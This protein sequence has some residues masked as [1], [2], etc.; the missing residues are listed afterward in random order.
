[1][2]G[3]GLWTI[4][5]VTGAWPAAADTPFYDRCVALD[6]S[7]RLQVEACTFALETEKLAADQ[8]AH[9][10]TRRATGYRGTGY[11]RYADA[12][13]EQAVRLAP[14]DPEILVAIADGAR[15][16]ANAGR[17]IAANKQL[18]EHQPKDVKALTGLG[19][20]YM[21][22]QNYTLAE[23]AFSRILALD[24]NNVGAL[25][26]RAMTLGPQQEFARGLVDMDRAV[27]LQD[28]NM[29]FRQQRGELE[30]YAGRFREA[31]TD[32]DLFF[33][34]QE[35][36]P[37]YRFR[38]AAKYYLGDFQGA[39]A[40][41][42]R[43][44]ALV[45]A[46]AHLA[47]W[48][49]FAEQRNGGGSLEEL[50]AIAD[51]TKDDWTASLIRLVTKQGSIDQALAL[52]KNGNKKLQMVRE[53]QTHFAAGEAALLAGDSAGARLQFA[54]AREHGVQVSTDQM[55]PGQPG[56]LP[57][58]NVIE[59]SIAGARLRELKQ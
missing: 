46:F 36:A 38:G 10:L 35:N 40:D 44:L 54:A 47:L 17:A 11:W 29:A 1:M 49:Y 14:D 37:F 7:A 31:I 32:L 20:A 12:D 21:M 15:L 30:L 3:W 55:V 9:A 13:L 19:V 22:Q 26:W 2:R 51:R 24:P 27:A 8:Q 5:F 18:L 58:D 34:A 45:P 56:S 41:F 4:V 59:F 48:R 33:A 52:A 57:L 16:N 6:A 43:D 25:Y 28:K 53:S 39:T 23:N 50:T 42:S